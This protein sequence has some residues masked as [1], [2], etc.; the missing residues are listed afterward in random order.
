MI[1]TR[2]LEI[3]LHPFLTMTVGGYEWSASQPGHITPRV[4]HLS[5]HFCLPSQII[6]EFGGIILDCLGLE[7]G[8]R[9]L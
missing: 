7:S 8:N 4:E 5:L 1:Y 6:V 3:Q 2:G 9:K